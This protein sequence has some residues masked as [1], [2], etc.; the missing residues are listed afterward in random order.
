MVYR[1]NT[2]LAV[3]DSLALGDEQT[4]L[5]TLR[6][7]ALPTEDYESVIKCATK[8]YT[9]EEC[10]LAY[11][12]TQT[13]DAGRLHRFCERERAQPEVYEAD[14]AILKQLLADAVYFPVPES[15]EN[16]RAAVSYENSWNYA[17]TYG[18]ERRHEGTDIMANIQQRGYYPVVSVSDGT[19]EKMGWLPQGGYRVGIRSEHGVYYYYAHLAEY[20]ADLEPG[21]TVKAGE[22]IGYMGDTGYSEVEGTTGNFPVHLHFGMYLNGTDGSEVSYNPY[23]LLLRLEKHRLRYRY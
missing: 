5:E 20:A 21:R 13:A 11:L 23:F 4:A 2:G 12:F 19:V 3:K 16:E 17:R 9:K 10:L 1:L 15:S 6:A 18:G 22:L 7:F 14:C 8:R